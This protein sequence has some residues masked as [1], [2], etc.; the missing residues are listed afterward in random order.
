[1]TGITRLGILDFGGR[2][3]QRPSWTAIGETVRA[4][5]LAE[6][7]GY[8]RYWLAEHQALGD[9]W[10][11]CAV[12]VGHLAAQ[13][14]TIRIGTAGVLLGFHDLFDVAADYRL[15][16]ALY[17]NRIDLG[18][19]GG[20]PSMQGL[21]ARH[22]NRDYLASLAELMDFL[23]RRPE[24]SI[25]GESLLVPVPTDVTVDV[26]WV[27]GSSARSRDAA[28]MHRA[29]F[30]YSLFHA[31]RRE[32]AIVADYLDRCDGEPRAAIC[33]AVLCAA[34]ELEV[35]AIR[36]RQQPELDAR[37][38]TLNVFGTALQCAEQLQELAA[39]Y[40]VQD[41][42]IH[43]VARTVPE[44]RSCYELIASELIRE[45]SAPSVVAEIG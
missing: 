38:A 23:R 41:V 14:S 26:P 3:A 33:V 35:H 19:A 11:G 37:G 44:R 32:P 29:A 7:L 39:A 1:M 40:R 9:A 18:V 45:A 42:V 22:E 31:P 24:D 25:A 16:S 43:D 10:G 27:L 17:P 12:M 21:H 13:T 15:L 36:E 6:R 4:V 34:T 28:L 30:C 20:S 8:H 5:R 2:R